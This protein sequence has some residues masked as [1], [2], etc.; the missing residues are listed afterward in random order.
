M[1]L[2]DMQVLFMIQNRPMT[3]KTEIC[4]A[5]NQKFKYYCNLRSCFAN[6]RKRATKTIF[7]PDCKTTRARVLGAINRLE[8]KELIVIKKM[9][10][11]D[12]KNH[13]GW[14]YMS[15]CF[16]TLKL[17]IGDIGT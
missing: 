15:C 12:G 13:R 7:K 14:D 5:I 17:C 4:R 8:K 6:P 1:N 11:A 16:S 10:K 9:K 2:L 3:H